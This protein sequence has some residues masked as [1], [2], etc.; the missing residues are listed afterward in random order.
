MWRYDANR[1]GASPHQL[2]AKLY[3][4][5]VRDNSPLKPAWPDQD[6]MQ[7][8]IA[9]EPI[10]QGHMLYFNSSRHDCIRALDTRTGA[11]KWKY[12]ADAPIRFAPVAWENRIYFTSDD[13]Y[14][15]C[16]HK[17]SG[18]LLW[19]V[20]GGPSDRKI[21]GNERLISTWPAR[22][23]PVIADGKVYFAASIWPFMG[24]FI[25]AVDARTGNTVWTN[26]GD[27]SLYMTQPH[28]TDAFASIA[29]QG[30][31]VAIGDKLLV[32]GGRSVPAL[33]DRTTGKFLRYQLA[34][35][36][37]RGGG[38]EVAAIHDI[39]FNGGVVFDI[40]TQE[41]LGSTAKQVVLTKDHVFT[42]ANGTC[43]VLDLEHQKTQ[44][45]D[46]EDGNGHKTTLTRWTMPEIATSKIAGAD[47]LIKA[48][49][50]P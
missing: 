10:V 26:D 38:S 36:G 19:K 42:C 39:F 11:E 21:I 31:L 15:Y 4:Q 13:G 25:H 30:P 33:F 18:Q 12:F 23:A 37:H 35:N 50:T 41:Y 3:L 1:S 48:G 27:G 43:R 45:A 9:R 34:E 16:L 29:P 46:T 32:P 14:L 7:F 40:A 47:T 2:P 44:S 22:G 28:N 24:I 5:W 20:R 6:K 8:D 49:S 17:D